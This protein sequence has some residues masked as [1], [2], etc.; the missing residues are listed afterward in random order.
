MEVTS[1]ESGEEDSRL[2]LK[3]LRRTADL[4]LEGERD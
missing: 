4:S 2:M 3:S 1:C